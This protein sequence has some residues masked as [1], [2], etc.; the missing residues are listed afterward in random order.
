ML[1][2]KKVFRQISSCHENVILN[3]FLFALKSCIILC[4]ILFEQMLFLFYY[5]IFHFIGLIMYFYS[6]ITVVAIN[7]LAKMSED[8]DESFV[9]ILS[10]ANFDRYGISPSAFS[11]I[12]TRNDQVKNKIH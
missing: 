6:S 11:K 3:L 10:D 9:I 12:L 2:K 8:H 7:E 4:L 1:G 5:K